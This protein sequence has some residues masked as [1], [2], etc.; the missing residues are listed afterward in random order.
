MKHLNE[1]NIR[2]KL[3]T[4]FLIVALI[5]SIASVIS[6]VILKVSDAMYSDALI[7][8]GFSQGDIGKLFARMGVLDGAVHDAIS[9]SDSTYQDNARKDYEDSL[10]VVEQ[11]FEDVQKTIST[12]EEQSY[13]D[14][15]RSS[16]S[17]YQVLAEE[18]L[19]AADTSDTKIIAQ[20]QDRVVN[21]LDPVYNE[22]Y[23]QMDQLMTVTVNHGNELS[24]SLTSFVWIA[25]AGIVVLIILAILISSK[26]GIN[27][28]KSI[29]VPVVACAD[30][31][32]RLSE[33]DLKSEVPTVTTKD[34]IKT[35]AD[36]TET[37][38]DNLSRIINDEN[39]LLAEM[40]E[41]NF[42]IKSTAEESYIGDFH[43]LLV[44]IREINSSLSTTLKEIQESSSQVAMAS[45]QMAQGATALAE[46]STDQA[47]A[48]EEVLATVTEVTSQV[49]KNAREAAEAS[50]KAQE[51]GE[52]ARESNAQM[53]QMTEAMNRI[54]VTSKQISE[55]IDSIDSIAT[56]TN[57][58]SLN[59][60]I[61]AA[62][63]GEAGRGF[64]V[65]AGEIG[66]LA[67]QSSEAANNTRQLIETSLAEVQS[68][69]AIAG[70]TA[71]S[72]NIVT[73][74]IIGVVDIADHVRESSESQAHSMEQ[75]SEGIGQI[76]SVIQSN[77]ATAEESSATSEELS[78]QAE[79]L[80][81]LVAKFR[82]KS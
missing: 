21:E 76:S 63:A 77:S 20:V 60:A 46:G 29:A 47:S 16:W 70:Q 36:A 11:Y 1:M 79:T 6:G 8:Y 67:T 61:E 7:N 62:R 81:D 75:L 59:A 72:L 3:T 41:G 65:V 17:E 19:E 82:L 39:Y 14:S 50:K 43:Q 58:L 78:A 35:L 48:V 31:L 12:S 5:G 73:E 15:A 30:R 13:L 32:K 80:N 56:Q 68:G 66:Q 54:D 40:A 26:I 42:N 38:V 22:I 49:E 25:L 55:I 33:G 28:A 18:L 51:I 53:A 52:Q 34:E 69:T 71:E 45:D 64:A 4:G 57:L 9:Y 2:K 74:G 23:N 44:S 24:A 37:I 27:I 10:P